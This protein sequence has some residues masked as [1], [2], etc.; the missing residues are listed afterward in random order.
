[1]LCKLH[2]HHRSQS[3][4]FR[5]QTAL[6]QIHGL[7]AIR[8]SQF[9]LVDGEVALR[10]YQHRDIFL[11]R[12]LSQFVEEIHEA[13]PHSSARYISALDGISL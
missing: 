6:A 2:H 10:T 9:H 11:L 8:H 4:C 5:T 13:P 12:G 7:V 1:M 3:G